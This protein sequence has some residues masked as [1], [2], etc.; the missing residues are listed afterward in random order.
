M[1][2]HDNQHA[3]VNQVDASALTAEAVGHLRA[4][5]G[6]YL[7]E[8]ALGRAEDAEVAD[9]V[10]QAH[11]IW[12]A[13]VHIRNARLC[14]LVYDEGVSVAAAAHRLGISRQMA[15]RILGDVDNETVDGIRHGLSRLQGAALRS[16]L[17]RMDAGTREALLR[18][19]GRRRHEHEHGP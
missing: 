18:A 5:V 7:E 6:A 11:A 4:I 2:A 15:R 9:L 19:A 1:Q 16:W 12:R 8:V 10:Q 14:I 3:R 17:H 13:A